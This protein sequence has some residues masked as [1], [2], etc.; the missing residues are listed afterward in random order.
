M[1]S[2]ASAYGTM[3]VGLFGGILEAFGSWDAC[4]RFEAVSLAQRAHVHAV[5]L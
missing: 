3:K 2:T 1:V 5:I 4:G